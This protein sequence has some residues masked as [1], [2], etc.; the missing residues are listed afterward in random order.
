MQMMMKRIPALALLLAL[1]MA[2]CGSPESNLQKARDLAAQGRYADAV[3][4][5]QKALAN[6]AG[7]PWLS[8]AWLDLARS[9]KLMGDPAAARISAN[10][11]L[12][13]AT[14]EPARFSAQLFLAELLIGDKDLAGAEK[15]LNGMDPATEKDPRRMALRTELAKAMGAAPLI[16]ASEFIGLDATRMVVGK[17]AKTRNIDTT[18]FPYVQRYVEKGK[19]TKIPSPDGKKMLWRGLSSDGYFLFISDADGRNQ[20]RLKDCKNAFQPSWAPDSK[21][22]IFSSINWKTRSR[23]LI[24]FDTSSGKGREGFKSKK[25]VGAMAAFSTDGSKIAFVYAGDLWMLNSNGIGLSKVNLKDQIKQRVKE[26]SLLAW[27]RDGSQ[28]AYQPKGYKDIFIINFV[29]RAS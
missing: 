16:Q 5:Y 13:T 27:S 26:A 8:S 10:Q 23:S 17:V 29:R 14:T 11:A 9:Q 2:G 21:R 12:A 1:W 15:T 20:E 18:V 25:G 6:P 4:L 7:Q 24:I 3:E 28:L 22:V 19:D